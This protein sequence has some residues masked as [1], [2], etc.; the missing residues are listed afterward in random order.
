MILP[1]EC[2]IKNA[3]D[4][5][6]R[7]YTSLQLDI[8]RIGIKCIIYT[9]EIGSRGYINPKNKAILKAILSKVKIKKQT[10]IISELSKLALLGSFSIYHA[11]Q[12][13]E[14]TTESYIKA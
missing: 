5:K 3:E 8:E 11:R 6:V 12:S 4:R 10:K 1:I 7:R 14:W 13:P 9:L 2:S